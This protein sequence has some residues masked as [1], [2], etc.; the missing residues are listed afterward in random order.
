MISDGESAANLAFVYA[1]MLTPALR[2]RKRR[3]TSVLLPFWDYSLLEGALW[4]KLGLD[5]AYLRASQV[6]EAIDHLE[7]ELLEAY[8]NIFK[9][10]EQP[11]GQ[12]GLTSW[13]NFIE[14]RTNGPELLRDIFFAGDHTFPTEAERIRNTYQTY[15]LLSSEMAHEE[16]NAEFLAA[17]NFGSDEDWKRVCSFDV[18]CDFYVQ[19]FS[20]STIQVLQFLE[21]MRNDEDSLRDLNYRARAILCWKLN[22]AN[23][24]IAYRFRHACNLV[25]LSSLQSLEATTRM[26]AQSLLEAVR[27]NVMISWMGAPSYT[28]FGNFALGLEELALTRRSYN[29]LRNANIRNLQDVV[30]KTEAELLASEHIDRQSLEEIKNRLA[31]LG[32]G[33]GMMPV[34]HGGNPTVDTEARA[35][36]GE[37]IGARTSNEGIIGARTTHR[38]HE[39]GRQIRQ[40][41]EK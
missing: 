33:L 29:H 6:R 24:T 23:A 15:L 9:Y 10:W 31:Q 36:H 41:E 35:T 19:D 5:T 39:E 25:F 16:P 18:Y 12:D 4:L 14:L 22:F 40:N 34:A 8:A 28:S 26:Q 38:K 20:W 32:I 3:S 13:C 7:P 21:D 17:L 37:V 11:A 1:V 2:E 30:Q 27:A